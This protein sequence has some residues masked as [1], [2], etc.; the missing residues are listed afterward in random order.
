VNSATEMG[1]WQIEPIFSDL[2]FLN[3]FIAGAFAALFFLIG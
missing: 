1:Q 2:S 3:A